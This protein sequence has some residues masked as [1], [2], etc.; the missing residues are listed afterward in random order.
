VIIVDSFIYIIVFQ[1]F[2]P[3]ENLALR[4]KKR[5]FRLDFAEKDAL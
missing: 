4:I 3:V 5:L 2:E 1:Q